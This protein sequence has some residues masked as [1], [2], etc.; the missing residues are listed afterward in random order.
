MT[1]WSIYRR[2]ADPATAR[3][4]SA[5]VSL[6]PSAQRAGAAPAPQAFDALAAV[7]FTGLMI[8]RAGYADRGAGIEAEYTSTLGQQ[9][10]VSPDGRLLFYDLRPWAR[11]LRT[12]LTKA[13]IDELR[14]KTLDARAAPPGTLT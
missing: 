4:E 6:G 9:P 8:D 13:E 5:K 11:D 1:A 12:R 14:R 7:G 2:Q 10:Q 3:D